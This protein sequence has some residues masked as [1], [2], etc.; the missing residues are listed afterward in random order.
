[1]LV[2][3]YPLSLPSTVGAAGPPAFEPPQPSAPTAAP[4]E[5]PSMP[6]IW[7]PPKPDTLTSEAEAITSGKPDEFTDEANIISGVG[8]E[9]GE[10]LVCLLPPAIT[11][12]IT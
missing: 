4:S 5:S 9:P 8:D 10:C 2:S 7:E 11:S 6:V 3:F 1:L 12:S